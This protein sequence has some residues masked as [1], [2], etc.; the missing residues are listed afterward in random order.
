M[1]LM[2]DDAARLLTKVLK[3]L[4]AALAWM[5]INTTTGIFFGW[6]FFSSSPSAGNYIFYAW[7][8]L[9]LA[10]LIWYFYKIWKEEFK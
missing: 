10:A 4:S 2:E 1:G 6:M 3:T 7:M 8:L 9:S 5:L